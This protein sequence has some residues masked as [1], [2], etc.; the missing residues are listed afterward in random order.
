LDLYNSAL[1]QLIKRFVPYRANLQTGLL[2][3]P[4]L[5]ERSK[6]TI[7]QP[8][9]N[10]LSYTASIDLT[11]PFPPSGKVEDPT[12]DP[13]ANYVPVA[14]I[15]GDESDYLVLEGSA[16]QIVPIN[17]DAINLYEFA[18]D[19]SEYGPCINMGT[20]VIELSGSAGGEVFEEAEGTIDLG[21]NG[22]GW[23]SRYLGSKY[24]Y[25]TYVSSGSN[26]RTLTYT[27][28]SRYDEYEA[29]EPTILINTYSSR[30]APGGQMYDQNIYYSRLFTGQ[31]AFTASVAFSSSNAT[32]LHPLTDR[33]GLRFTSSFSGSG[34]AAAT[35]GGGTYG[36]SLYGAAGLPDSISP[37]TSS[38]Y[39][40][41]DSTN[42][43]YFKPYTAGTGLY[44]GSFAIDAF[45][46][47]R[48]DSRTYDYLYRVT[49]T[50]DLTGSSG[51]P[52]ISLYFGG[53]DSSVTQSYT[54]SGKQTNTYV[55]KAIGTE[56]GVRVQKSSFSNTEYIKVLDLKVE[57]L[58]YRAQVQDFHL[59][60]SRGMINARYEGCKLTSTDYNVDSPD[61]ID[62]GPVITVTLV[63]GSVLATSPSTQPG[64]FQIQ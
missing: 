54:L 64:T 42:G 21:V 24:A 35:Y 31:R 34:P 22:A 17:D 27:T 33:F 2:I 56:L 43:L 9:V 52:K 51:D 57:P 32:D 11:N 25:M 47:D 14:T 19:Q 49:I 15:G 46:Y 41:L 60:S 6:L 61:T 20:D 62:N 44:T 28:A 36:T 37:F 18:F 4:T 23:N 7:K 1:F 3:E 58:N 40:S 30:I 13:L 63:G 10:D 29:I 5:I 16:Q 45:M 12:N 53:F 39:W 8:T 50:T 26:P 48:A 38:F 59:N 55:T